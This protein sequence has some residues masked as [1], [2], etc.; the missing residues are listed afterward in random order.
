MAVREQ[1]ELNVRSVEEL[2]LE[3]TQRREKQ[4]EASVR[5]LKQALSAKERALKN[6]SDTAALLTARIDTA[7]DPERAQ[8]RWG[9]GDARAAVYMVDTVA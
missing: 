2:N 3:S 4:L 8:V 9:A 1:R 7:R 5:R 6:T